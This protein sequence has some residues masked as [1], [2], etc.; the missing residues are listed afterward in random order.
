MYCLLVDDDPLMVEL[1]SRVLRTAGHEV[2]GVLGAEIALRAMRNRKPS[3]VLLDARMPGMD[4]FAMLEAVRADP[5]WSDIPVVMVT[6]LRTQA[7]VMKA[8]QLGASGYV[9]KPFD[10]K[11]LLQRVSACLKSGVTG[12]VASASPGGAR[13]AAD[14]DNANGLWLL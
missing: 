14:A 5:E 4:G 12:G 6:S 9:I 13:S 1:A 10:Q 8:Q 7:D 11:Q 3:L 2:H